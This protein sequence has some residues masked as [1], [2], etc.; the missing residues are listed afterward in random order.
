MDLKSLFNGVYNGRRVL[1]TGHTGFKGSWLFHWLSLMGAKLYGISLDPNTEP[2]H[3]QLLEPCLEND[4]RIDI[5]NSDKLHE[6]IDKIKPEIVF[7]LA[8]QPLVRYSYADP[9]S[10][11]KTNIIGT[12]NLYEALRNCTSALAIVNATTDKVYAEQYASLGYN[13]S[14]KLGGHDPY[15]TSKA[16]VELISDS[17]RKCFF[18]GK[19]K[20]ATARSGNVIGGGDWSCDRLI[21]DAIRCSQAGTPLLIRYPNAIRPWQHV[22]EPLSG[23]LLLGQQL[24]QSGCYEGAWNFGPEAEGEVSVCQL[25]AMLQRYMPNIQLSNDQTKT[26]H[27]AGVLRLDHSKAESILCWQPVWTIEESIR[28]TAQWYVD[29]YSQKK[30]N[31]LSDLSKYINDAKHKRVVWAK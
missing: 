25:I 26:P 16:C 6:L 13:E 18:D 3:W 4:F 11:Y 17:Y 9:V 19:L 30:V 8:A 5:Q 14:D 29:F 20:L 21:P 24:L 10:T 7:H 22:L 12:I 15:S 2:N 23:Y 31:T 28:M 27:E 1:I